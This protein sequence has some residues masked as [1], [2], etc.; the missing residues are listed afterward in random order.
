MRTKGQVGQVICTC[1]RVGELRTR[2]NGK[3]LPFL[4][5][6]HC[7]MKQG[8]E[9]LRDE[10]VTNEK[11]NHSL[12][13]YGQFPNSSNEQ[14]GNLKLISNKTNENV[15]PEQVVTSN[16]VQVEHQKEWLPDESNSP[17]HIKEELVANPSKAGTSLNDTSSTTSKSGLSLG[18]KFG[19][20]FITLIAA[21]V[22]ISNL[23]LSK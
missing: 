1:G 7:G 17:E 15:M 12:G 19:I 8:K 10:W 13:V 2:G 9:A 3:F 11:P 14:P 21:V 16:E 20:G 18:A 23:N 22:G 6:K 4:M 5:C